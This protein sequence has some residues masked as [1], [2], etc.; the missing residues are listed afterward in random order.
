MHNSQLQ[1]QNA[2]AH[3]SRVESELKLIKVS[4]VTFVTAAGPYVSML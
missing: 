2:A 3:L 4:Q 1:S